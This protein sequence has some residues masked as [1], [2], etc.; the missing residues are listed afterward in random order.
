[1]VKSVSWLKCFAL[2]T[3]LWTKLFSR[4]SHSF[5]TTANCL[6]CSPLCRKKRLK[7]IRKLMGKREKIRK[8]PV[9][10]RRKRTI[11]KVNLR[12]VKLPK[13]PV[14]VTLIKIQTVLPWWQG[15]QM[16]THP[17]P[18]REPAQTR[19][20][21]HDARQTAD[22]PVLLTMAGRITMESILMTRGRL[23]TSYKTWS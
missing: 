18:L 17:A 5:Y 19:T 11:V 10:H 12:V 15:V 22:R 1:M 8:T 13:A 7:V 23:W 21:P 4:F 16:Q 9:V 2:L 20:V 3:Q 6:L 14:T